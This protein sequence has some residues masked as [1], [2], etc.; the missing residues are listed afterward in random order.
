MKRCGRLRVFDHSGNKVTNT[1]LI[2]SA[3]FSGAQVY[4]DKLYAM[5]ADN[6]KQ[7]IVQVFHLP[8]LDYDQ[9]LIIEEKSHLGLPMSFDIGAN[10]ISVAFESG[11]VISWSLSKMTFLTK[12][13]YSEHTLTHIATNDKA[14]YVYDCK[15]TIK[16]YFD[17]E[18]TA[19]KEYRLRNICVKNNG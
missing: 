14:F 4:N 2:S 10:E 15:G 18:R 11:D 19:V 17:G 3:G 9:S 6:T 13:S 7:E 1:S 12:E 5:V 8:S 16:R